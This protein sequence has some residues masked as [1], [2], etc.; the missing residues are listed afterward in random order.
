MFALLV[1]RVVALLVL[2]DVKYLDV[3]V[4]V[5]DAFALREVMLETVVVKPFVVFRVTVEDM[6]TG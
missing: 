4:E 6:V 1:L 5:V 2:V 3:E